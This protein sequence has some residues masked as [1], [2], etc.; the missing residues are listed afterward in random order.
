MTSTLPPVPMPPPDPSTAIPTEAPATTKNNW[1]GNTA[2]VTGLLGIGLLGVIFGALGLQSVRART[3]TNRGLALTGVIAGT[4]WLVVGVAVAIGVAALGWG[5]PAGSTY[6]S[7]DD[8]KVGDCFVKHGD[9][10]N[11]EESFEA[12]GLYTI[13][14][15]SIHYGEVYYL[16]ELAGTTF[17]G[18]DEV[19][20][21]TDEGCFSD[22]AASGVDL[23]KAA[24]LT[25]FYVFPTEDTW[26]RG[27]RAY[28]C[29]LTSEA[30]DLVGSILLA[31]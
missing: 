23:D 30:E 27:D 20:A 28:G 21:L 4:V 10:A 22:D 2:A 15:A 6:T 11:D 12:T 8:L 29:M 18:R 26:S 25:Y 16:G 5:S 13:D 7:L 3:A 31:P 14:C 1:Q 19:I 24:E 9:V 17:P